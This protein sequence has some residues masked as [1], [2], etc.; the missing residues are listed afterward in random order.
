MTTVGFEDLRGGGD[1]DYHDFMFRL[2]NVLDPLP[3]A[4]VPEPPILFRLACGMIG[5][6]LQRRRVF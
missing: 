2:T 4:D 5:L 1:E 6:F 3:P